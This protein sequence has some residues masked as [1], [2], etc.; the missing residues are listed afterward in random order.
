MTVISPRRAI[1]GVS[2]LLLALPLGFASKVWVENVLQ[3]EPD[4]GNG[5]FEL[6]LFGIPVL[7]GLLLLASAI[8]LSSAY[9]LSDKTEN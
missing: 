9:E 3:Y 2:L 8:R 4:H 5:L 6:L 1:A 7:L